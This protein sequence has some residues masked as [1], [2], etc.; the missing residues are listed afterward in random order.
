MSG[1]SLEFSGDFYQE[2]FLPAYEKQFGEEPTSP[3]HAHAFDGANM[4]FDAI[5]AVATMAMNIVEDGEFDPIFEAALE[6]EQA[7]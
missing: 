3:F 2:E 4:L 5:E 7:A 1:P 6:L